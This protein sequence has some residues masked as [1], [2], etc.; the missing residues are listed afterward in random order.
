MHTVQRCGLLLPMFRG[1]AL[2]QCVCV[3]AVCR[4]NFVKFGHVLF[5]LCKRTDKHAR[6]QT[7]AY[8]SQYFAPAMEHDKHKHI[9]CQL[10][11]I[12]CMFAFVIEGFGVYVSVHLKVTVCFIPPALYGCE[13]R[14]F[15]RNDYLCWSS[16]SFRRGEA[17]GGSRGLSPPQPLKLAPQTRR[18]DCEYKILSS[19]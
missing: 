14:Y 7:Q 10:Y 18:T 6:K 9:V 5:E 3:H 1:A 11:S 13:T 2:C 12:Y 8:S 16:Y 4:E 17:K 19:H 15:N